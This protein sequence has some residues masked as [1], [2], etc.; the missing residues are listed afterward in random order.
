[1]SLHKLNSFRWMNGLLGEQSWKQITTRTVTGYIVEVYAG[2]N[3][4]VQ[5]GQV[6]PNPFSLSDSCSIDY[7]IFLC[8]HLLPLYWLLPINE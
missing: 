8:P 1:M 6:L 5:I 7:H 2:Y 4:V 3:V